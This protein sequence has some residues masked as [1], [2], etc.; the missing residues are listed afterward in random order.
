MNEINLQSI[1]IRPLK[2][3]DF[4]YVLQWSK[5]ATFCSANDWE[6]NR[7][8]QDL[9]TW[10]IHCVNRVSE[11]FVRLGIE[12]ENRL[13]GYADLA[14][15]KGNTAEL[16]IA[17]GESGF[18]GKGIGYNASKCMMDYA[19]K[20]LGITVFNAETHEIN[21]R[22]RKMLERIGFKEVSRIGSEDYLGTESQLIQYRFS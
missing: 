15:I 16:G 17:I 20:Y 11:D 22:S 8:E 14:C 2:I 19:A 7:D 4:V 12:L 6:K 3:D 21:I 10:W 18:W 9:Y 5:D 1:K 13:I